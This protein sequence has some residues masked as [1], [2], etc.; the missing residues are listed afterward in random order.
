[1]V[2]VSEVSEF[3]Y[4][5]VDQSGVPKHATSPNTDEA[6]TNAT[7]IEADAVP[8]TRVRSVGIELKGA[9]SELISYARCIGT[10]PIDQLA[11]VPD[12]QAAPFLLRT[13]ER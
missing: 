8:I 6:N 2:H 3:V 13:S 4:H 7:V 11:V 5:R 10:E 1:V 9:Q 12:H